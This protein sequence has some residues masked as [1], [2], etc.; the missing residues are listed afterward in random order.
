[1]EAPSWGV[2]RPCAPSVA[3]SFGKVKQ[4]DLQDQT[5]IY[6]GALLTSGWLAPAIMAAPAPPPP[7]HPTVCSQTGRLRAVDGLNLS[8][9]TAL[10]ILT[11]YCSGTLIDPNR[12]RCKWRRSTRLSSTTTPGASCLDCE[13][14]TLSLASRCTSTCSTRTAP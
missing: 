9:M 12:A 8:A 11:N 5:V 2:E 6:A 14:L 10:P 3:P 13:V 7:L 4:S 1:M